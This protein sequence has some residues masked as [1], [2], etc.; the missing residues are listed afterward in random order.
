MIKNTTNGK[1]LVRE[2]RFC[3]NDLQKFM[4][5]RFYPKLRDKGL[6]FPFEKDTKISLDM[7]FVFYHIDVLWLDAGRKVI[8]MK[9][10][11]MPFTFY[12]PKRHARYVIELPRGTIRRTKTKIKD[13]IGF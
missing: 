2:K 7:L 10:D 5:L 9:E 1:T 3:R 4:G 13:R 8:E 12:I 6:V 11:F